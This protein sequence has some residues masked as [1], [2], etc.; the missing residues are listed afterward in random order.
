MK[1]K[2]DSKNNQSLNYNFIQVKNNNYIHLIQ[3]NNHFKRYNQL[4]HQ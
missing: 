1:K 2:N 3:A 4:G